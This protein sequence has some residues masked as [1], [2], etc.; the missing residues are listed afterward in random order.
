MKV[1]ISVSSESKL[2]LPSLHFFISFTL[3]QVLCTSAHRDHTNCKTV[4]VKIQLMIYIYIY[5]CMY[6]CIHTYMSNNIK[7]GRKRCYSILPEVKNKFHAR[8]VSTR[9]PRRDLLL[10]SNIMLS[11]GRDVNITIYIYIYIYMHPGWLVCLCC[12][13]FHL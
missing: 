1:K 12:V 3:S 10:T 8:M 11:C 2:S 13:Q 6:V 7:L 5:V 4:N 9:K